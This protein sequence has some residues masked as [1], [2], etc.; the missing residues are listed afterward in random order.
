MLIYPSPHCAE[1]IDGQNSL[2]ECQKALNPQRVCESLNVE[3]QMITGQ[4]TN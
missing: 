2:F 1:V 4:Q 3:S